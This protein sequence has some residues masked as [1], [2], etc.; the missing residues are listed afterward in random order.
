VVHRADNGDLQEGE[1]EFYRLVQELN[2]RAEATRVVLVNQFGWNRERC[3]RRMPA[4]MT[5]HDIR[6]GT[7][8][9]FGQSIYEPFGIAQIEPL[10]YGA[11]SVVSSVCGCLGFIRQVSKNRLPQ[12]LIV[13]D[14][15]SLPEGVAAGE[16]HVAQMIG[17][18]ERDL[19]ESIEAQRVAQKVMARLPNS[20]QARETLLEQGYGLSQQMGWDVVVEHYLLPALV[21]AASR[22][23]PHGPRA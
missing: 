14:Y 17:K 12:N 7:D 3:G 10:G 2:A 15:V 11:L 22:E 5:D 4:D 19:I 13:A 23:V 6:W 8:L 21:R 9:E 18:A 20:E 16:P 1:A